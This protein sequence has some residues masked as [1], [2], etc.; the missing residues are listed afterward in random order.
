M[1]T[2]AG[3]GMG[4]QI[5]T[6]FLKNG[7]TVIAVEVNDNALNTFY[8]EL[9][10]EYDDELVKRFIPFVGDISTQETNEKMIEKDI[11]YI[12]RVLLI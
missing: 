6:D 1:V 11:V 12:V 8:E 7:A 3:A 10:S 2:G 9:K 4:K 5:T